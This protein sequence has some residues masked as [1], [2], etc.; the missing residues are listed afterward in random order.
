[1]GGEDHVGWG[2]RGDGDSDREFENGHRRPFPS[3]ES[4]W[5]L[6]VDGLKTLLV[7]AGAGRIQFSCRRRVRSVG[8]SL[9]LVIVLSASR[10]LTV[11][12]RGLPVRLNGP[13]GEMLSGVSGPDGELLS[14]ANT[15]LDYR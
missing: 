4:M 6:R 15:G 12:W 10:C 11:P 2:I 1:V 5:N 9:P 8:V 14:G 13:D 7:G 3:R